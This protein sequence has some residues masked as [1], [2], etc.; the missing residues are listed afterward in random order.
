MARRNSRPSE[1]LI[2]DIDRLSDEGRGI[3]VHEGKVVFV[4]DAL[5]GER[6][7]ALV[8]TAKSRYAE[9]RTLEVLQAAAQRAAPPCSHYGK[10]GGCALQHMAV[11]A[12]L[13]FKE[14]ILHEKLAHH[15]GA[16]E[17]QRLPVISSP[18][19]SYRRKARLAVRFV[20]T[21][22]RV[23]VGFRERHS[24]RVADIDSCHVLDAR[25]SALIPRL[26]E[27]INSWSC[28]DAIP[29]VEV[30]VGDA[31]PGLPSHALVFRHLVPLRDS[32]LQSLREFGEREQVDIY[33]QPKGP[34]TVHKFWPEATPD[35]LYYRLDAF[36]VEFA[37]HPLDFT[38]VNAGVNRLMVSRALELLQPGPGERV[39]DLFCGLG[40]FT[41]PLARLAGE[42][43]GVEGVAQ[44]VERGTE[45]AQRN[46]IS[47]ARFLCADLAQPPSTHPWLQAGF[48]KV[49]LDP[50]RSGALEV[51][52]A[53]VAA[54]PSRIVYVS[55]NPTTLARDAGFLAEQGYV[56]HA[57]GA[58]D[59]FP[60]TAHVEAMALFLPKEGRRG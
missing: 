52:P 6:V 60:H 17:W 59:M 45:N 16:G 8:H 14:N 12:Q 29:Q 28:R 19:S 30:A 22:E 54:R 26:A 27:L 31:L 9:A 20:A 1:P 13:A 48:D 39:L 34:E 3:A 46:G 2:L 37:F 40:N 5:P 18:A 4:S 58:M 53:V 44:M 55:C 35:R 43:L 32:E 10:C 51:L 47:N 21:K 25:V 56:L 15:A 38:Q 42:V 36:D 11:E 57:A 41:L 7:S 50:P 23:L 24:A 33:L 49:L